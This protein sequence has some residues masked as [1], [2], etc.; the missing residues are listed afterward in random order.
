MT[1]GAILIDRSYCQLLFNSQLPPPRLDNVIH[2]ESTFSLLRSLHSWRFYYECSILDRVFP[3]WIDLIEKRTAFRIIIPERAKEILD[4][5]STGG[6]CIERMALSKIQPR[7]RES[8]ELKLIH[9]GVG[10]VSNDSSQTF[11]NVVKWKDWK[12]G[13]RVDLTGDQKLFPSVLIP[14]KGSKRSPF[15]NS[16]RITGNGYYILRSE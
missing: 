7:K 6:D 4:Y 10:R 15:L 13:Y 5:V 14:R 2:R 9:V 11:R 1:R 16:T 12:S 8:W 3:F